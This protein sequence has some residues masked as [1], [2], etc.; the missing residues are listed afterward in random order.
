MTTTHELN[1]KIE[2]DNTLSFGNFT[3]DVKQKTEGFMFEGNSYN[4]KTYKEST[5]LTKNKELLLETV[6][7]A[8]IHHF[9]K[10]DLEAVF[11]ITGASANTMVTVQL[12][13]DTIYRIS[14]GN[15]KNKLGSM[16][17]GVSGKLSFSLDLS[18]G[19]EQV[20]RLEKA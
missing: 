1:I 11:G 9:H 4:V 18:D 2:D 20:V 7:G 13:E 14:T 10:E 3:A 17:S 12:Q 5:R 19:K 6:P 15:G 8:N 16:S